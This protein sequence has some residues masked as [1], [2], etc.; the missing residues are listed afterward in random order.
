MTNRLAHEMSPYLR[1]HAHNPVDWYPWGDEA[2]ARAKR[3]DKPLLVS[4]GYSAC[5]WCHVMERESFDHPAIA[6]KMNALFVNV[7]VDREER[8][9]LDQLYQT[10]VQLMGRSGGWPLTVFLTPQLEAFFAGTYFPPEPRHGMPSFPEVLDAVARA[11]ETQ[12]DQVV[13]SAR[14]ITNAVKSTIAGSADDDALPP[15]AIAVAAQ[16]LARRFDTTHGGFGD[17]PKFPNTSSLD[18]LLRAAAN[19]DERARAHLVL[20]L[21]E[22]RHG[23]IYDQIGLGFHRYA[24]DAR[25]R[26]PHF[27]KMLYDNALLL[28]AYVDAYRLTGEPRFA[29]T[30]GE[31]ITYLERE[32]RAEGGAFYATQDADSEGEEGKFFVWTPDQLAAVLGEDVA[33]IVGR[34][35]GV[36]ASGNFEH[37]TSVLHVS[38]PLPTLAKLL[39]RAEPELRTILEE[40]RQ[41]LFLSRELRPKP[42][43]DEKI[44]AVWNGFAIS[45]LAEAAGALGEDRY[46]ALAEG[47]IDFVQDQMWRND[48]LARLAMGDDVKGDGFLEDYASVANAALDFYEA[49]LGTPRETRGLRARRF[50]Q[51]L[52]AAIEA[53]FYEPDNARFLFADRDA[54]DL[55]V[56]ASDLHD[57]ATPSGTALAVQA[58]LRLSEERYAAIA[59]RVLR[60]IAKDAAQTPFAFGYTLGAIDFVTRGP[61]EIHVV[62]ELGDP[63]GKALLDV[64]RKAYVPHRVL[65]RI[66]PDA[67]AASPTLGAQRQKDGRATA[68]VC[69]NR[70]CTPPIT[71][72]EELSKALAR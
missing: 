64:A 13:E 26:V 30:V 21:D 66:D 53:R 56:R 24:T 2:L 37:G 3:E 67:P 12:R 70:T 6:E 43:R 55:V 60:A 71:S 18:V 31:T 11:Y 49:S 7:K 72:T 29:T 9:D 48:R 44:I 4:I 51:E 17:A 40:A 33:K 63:A 10:V 16:R 50:A 1:Q 14:E 59:E 61:T 65:A 20:T 34:Y 45:A 27:E 42:F 32:M 68:Y 23:G 39:D 52:A 28:R 22:M 15:D 69:A 35:F 25:W 62:A 36:D 46:L 8:P 19:G 38:R 47:A 57:D 41:K 54:K 5:H 58:L